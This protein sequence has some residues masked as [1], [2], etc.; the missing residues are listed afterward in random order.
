MHH[1]HDDAIEAPGDAELISA[2]RGGDVDAYGELFEPPRRGRAPAGPPARLRPAT[3]TTWS[4]R[5]SP[6]CSSS[7]SAAAARTSP[8]APTCSP[9]YAG[10]TSTRSAPAPRLHTTDDLTPFDPGVPFRDTAVEGFESAAAARAFASLPERWQLVL[11]HTEV[12]GQKP[13]DVAPLL[14]M[15]ANSV[16][17]LAY[18]AREGLRQAFLRCTS[19]D[20][21]RRRPAAWTHDHLGAYVRNGISRRDADQGRG[22]PR[23]LPHA[24]RRST[25]SSPRSTPT[26]PGILAPLLLGGAARG[27]PRPPPGSRRRRRG[28]VRC[29]AAP[30]TWSRPTPRPSRSPGSPRRCARRRR[31]RVADSRPP[32]IVAGE[33]PVRPVGPAAGGRPVRRRRPAATRRPP[34]RGPTPAPRRSTASRYRH[35]P[36]RCHDGATRARRPPRTDADPAGRHRTTGGRRLPDAD[37]GT[38]ATRPTGRR[39]RPDHGP[40]TTHADADAARRPAARRRPAAGPDATGPRPDPDP[41]PT[42]GPRSDPDRPTRSRPRPRPGDPPC[43][44]RR[45]GRRDRRRRR[46]RRPRVTVVGIPPASPPPWRSRDAGRGPGPDSAQPAAAPAGGAGRRAR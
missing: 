41:D 32:A 14:G 46:E 28:L 18:R 30:A 9:P 13:A 29:S 24:A 10:S 3:P 19:Q 7:C 6:R 44:P 38:A 37:P 21:R 17:A 33:S 23:R 1:E 27:L 39:P 5:R 26:S 16:S 45:A 36:A 40:T 35:A 25:S 15:S 42:A 20:A 43:R 4:P 22:P 34:T 31:P 12:E 8:S 11:W 2:V